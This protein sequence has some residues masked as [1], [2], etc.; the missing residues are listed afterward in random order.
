MY[1]CPLKHVVVLEN[2]SVQ[3]AGPAGRARSTNVLLG[4]EVYLW[5]LV[6]GIV[7][8][9]CTWQSA[10][11]AP[12]VP[13]NSPWRAAG[14]CEGSLPWDT[15][16]RDSVVASRDCLHAVL[17]LVQH[18]HCPLHPRVMH[19]QAGLEAAVWDICERWGRRMKLCCAMAQS[20]CSRVFQWPITGLC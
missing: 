15:G 9:L 18:H 11:E 16:C 19:T 5:C 13:V 10:W 17:L 12:K 14:I 1:I 8:S 4:K 7:P 3:A 20:L 6:T 2:W